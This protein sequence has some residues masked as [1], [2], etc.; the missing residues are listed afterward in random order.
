MSFHVKDLVVQ[1]G[2]H[3]ALH[4]VTLSFESGAL[5]LL[6]R[7][8]IRVFSIRE[9]GKETNLIEHEEEGVLVSDPQ[10]VYSGPG[11]R[12]MIRTWLGRVRLADVA[13][14]TRIE[15]RRLREYRAGRRWPKRHKERVIVEALMGVLAEQAGG[16]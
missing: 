2:R 1:Y 9:I 11:E 3:T 7:R 8:D 16:G 4:G 15:E 5:G 12:E 13:V 10:A 14:R 6:G